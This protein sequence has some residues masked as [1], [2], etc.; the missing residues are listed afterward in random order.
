MFRVTLVTKPGGDPANEFIGFIDDPEE[1]RDID[2]GFSFTW[3]V[4]LADGRGK[5]IQNCRAPILI[6]F[7]R[8]CYGRARRDVDQEPGRFHERYS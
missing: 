7:Q 3:P 1:I 8:R 2:D 4:R 5:P 6:L